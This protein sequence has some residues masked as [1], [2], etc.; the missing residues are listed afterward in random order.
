MSKLQI[1]QL[2]MPVRSAKEQ[3][4][5]LYRQFLFARSNK[6]HFYDLIELQLGNRGGGG[7]RQVLA[8]NTR[9]GSKRLRSSV[10]V[11][12]I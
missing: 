12:W 5:F 3:D 11:R 4:A 1:S 9:D 8:A 6:T 2:L 7:R 10:S